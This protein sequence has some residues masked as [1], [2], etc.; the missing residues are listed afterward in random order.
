MKKYIFILILIFAVFTTAASNTK[1]ETAKFDT[2]EG[3]IEITFIGHASLM[4]KFKGKVIHVDPFS[5]MADYSNFPKADIVLITHHHRDHLDPAA[6]KLI[7]KKETKIIAP[8]RCAP[9][10]KNP[11]VMNNGN[12]KSILGIDIDAVPA[13]NI[14]NKRKSGEAYHVKGVGNGYVI[15]LSEKKIYIA[16]DT[17][18]VP[19]MK[20]L[21]NIDVA[22][23]PMNLP[24]TM[25]PEM[26][27]RAALSFMPK[28][29]Y[30]YH[31]GKTDRNIL[32]KL[33]KGKK[34]D[35]RLAEFYPK[36]K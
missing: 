19:E 34:I 6:L 4:L 26:T 5:R 15:S 29:L 24:Y 8:K 3:K 9:E 25:T 13:Y 21:K 11:I 23:L 2:K 1:Y 16:G 28:I 31:Y 10:L 35:V 12:K 30:P 7:L 14:V 20:N 36:K 18:N 33:L 22:F 32:V 17:E 27:A